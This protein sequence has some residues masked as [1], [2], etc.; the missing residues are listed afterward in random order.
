MAIHKIGIDLGSSNTNI[1]VE[2]KGIVLSEPT[3]V[4]VDSKSGLISSGGINAKALAEKSPEKYV[5][6]E[7]INQGLISEYDALERLINYFVF[8]AGDFSRIIKPPLV[9]SVPS[10]V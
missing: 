4:A 3:V 8:K 5:L 10:Q 7:P 6:I 2:N 9:I 1:Y